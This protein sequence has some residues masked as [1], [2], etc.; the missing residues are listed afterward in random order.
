MP[1]VDLISVAPIFK[2]LPGFAWP[3]ALIATEPS[4]IQFSVFATLTRERQ[5]NADHI[6]VP[7]T[8]AGRQ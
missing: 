5:Q 1:S 3:D 6:F 2:W 8:I 7:L 4:E